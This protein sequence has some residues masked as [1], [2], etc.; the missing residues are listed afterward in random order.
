MP[1]RCGSPIAGD[2]GVAGQQAVDQRAVGVA[3]AGMHDQPGRLVDD[4]HVLVVVDD[5]ELRPSDRRRVASVVGSLVSSTS[6]C[7]P[8]CRRSLP[9]DA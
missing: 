5:R 7:W 1:G 3:G 4:D 2:L 8:S 6:M 9:D